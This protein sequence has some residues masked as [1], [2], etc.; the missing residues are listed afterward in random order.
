MR[1]FL[2][3]LRSRFSSNTRLLLCVGEMGR[4][5][6]PSEYNCM[7]WVLII[8]TSVYRHFYSYPV[9][10]ST[11]FLKKKA[12]CRRQCVY[13]W[14]CSSVRHLFF[15]F[16]DASALYINGYQ[17]YLIPQVQMTP[18]YIPYFCVYLIKIHTHIYIQV[19]T[20]VCFYN[21]Q[22]DFFEIIGLFSVFVTL[23]N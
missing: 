5:K 9:L 18:Y 21:I 12:Y 8:M 2:F 13:Y 3:L 7:K 10:S 19:C 6:R 11:S 16:P 22:F 1:D 14:H 15:F 20:E 17:F 23:D 4:E